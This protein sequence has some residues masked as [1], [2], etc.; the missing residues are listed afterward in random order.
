MRTIDPDAEHVTPGT[1][2]DPRDYD[3]DHCV[4]VLQN[5]FASRLERAGTPEDFDTVFADPEQPSLFALGLDTV[6]TVLTRP[7]SAPA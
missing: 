2:S 1:S 6:R 4:C 5:N 3:V 7:V